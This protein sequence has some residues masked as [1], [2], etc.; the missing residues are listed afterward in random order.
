[1]KR[2]LLPTRKG[3]AKRPSDASMLLHALVVALRDGRPRAD[4]IKLISAYPRIMNRDNPF[5]PLIDEI[6]ELR[7]HA[8]IRFEQADLLREV[9]GKLEAWTNHRP[10]RHILPDRVRAFFKGKLAF[11]GSHNLPKAPHGA[12]EE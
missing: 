5:L 2:N 1:M 12:V 3:K 8:G 11:P 6:G 10:K 9:D 4:M 7:K